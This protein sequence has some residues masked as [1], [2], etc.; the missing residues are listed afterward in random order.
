MHVSDYMNTEDLRKQALE[1]AQLEAILK[2]IVSKILDR[3]ARERLA[4]LRIANPKLA[5][6]LEIYLVQQF[7]GGKIPE[8]MTDEHLVELIR[9]LTR[10]KKETKIVRK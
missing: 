4:N 2:E 9:Y 1:Q 3:K 6:Q 8:I 10:G 7:N 5:Q